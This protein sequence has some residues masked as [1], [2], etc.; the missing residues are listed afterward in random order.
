MINEKRLK[1]ISSKVINV[2][3]LETSEMAQTL[4]KYRKLLRKISK[5]YKG[6]SIVAKEYK[7]FQTSL[8]AKESEEY[9]NK[10]LKEK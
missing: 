9:I 7:L 6:L 10:F 8:A 3:T 4:L 1:L 2:G 5:D